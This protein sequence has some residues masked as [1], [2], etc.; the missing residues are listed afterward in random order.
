M[1]RA[2]FE[3]R[4]CV[5][6]EKKPL[7]D[8]LKPLKQGV[9]AAAGWLKVDIIH[10]LRVICSQVAHNSRMSTLFH[11]YVYTYIID[12]VCPHAQIFLSHVGIERPAAGVSP[13]P[14]STETHD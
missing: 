9:V 3:A 6:W 11:S 1:A 13:L 14:F 2:S 8:G 12:Q 10:G 4:V 7:A 5:I